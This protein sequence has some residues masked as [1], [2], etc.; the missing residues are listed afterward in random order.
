MQ[1]VLIPDL[2]EPPANWKGV[3][4]ALERA[5]LYTTVLDYKP[6]RDED[7]SEI[8]EMISAHLIDKTV[9]VG[10]GIGGRIAVQLAAEKPHQLAGIILMSTPAMKA[11]GVTTF[12]AK[13]LRF[14]LTPVRILIP[15]YFR[16]KLELLYKRYYP[17]DP[18][19]MLYRRIIADEQDA[20]LAKIAD[21]LLLLWGADD[22]RVNPKVAGVISE[23]LDYADVPHD[24]QVVTNSDGRLHQTNPDLLAKY[25]LSFLDR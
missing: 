19:K 7:V 18:K 21:P 1:A 16:H 23:T 25:V 3:V 24:L 9:V 13:L 8:V 10:Y 2:Y 11:P 20:F 14:V 4:T 22:T 15:Y 12:F 6:P 5:G 17:G